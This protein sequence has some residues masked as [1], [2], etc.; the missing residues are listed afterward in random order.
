VKVVHDPAITALGSAFRHKVRVEVHLRDGA[1]ESET[2]EAPRGSEQSF[3]STDEIVEKF[4]KLTRATMK[5]EHQAQLIDAVLNLEKL[6]DV[7]LLARPLR[8][9]AEK[10]DV[11]KI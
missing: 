5:K 6:P 10:A 2:R 1:V 8:I 4:S 7:R 3:A 9:P 11:R